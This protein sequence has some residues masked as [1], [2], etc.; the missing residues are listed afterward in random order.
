M[1]V[2]QSF[3]INIDYVQALGDNFLLIKEKY[4]SMGQTYI[5]SLSQRLN[6]L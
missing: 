1:C 2:H 5:R 3:I 6:K 4:L